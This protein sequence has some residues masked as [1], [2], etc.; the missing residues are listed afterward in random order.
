MRHELPSVCLETVNNVHHEVGKEHDFAGRPQAMRQ[1]H[2]YQQGSLL[3]SENG[4]DGSLEWQ[5][6]GYV[7]GR[8]TSSF[9]K[10][11]ET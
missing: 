5:N 11:S 7:P 1:N 9:R 3:L 10:N 6:R 2:I 8:L 4:Q